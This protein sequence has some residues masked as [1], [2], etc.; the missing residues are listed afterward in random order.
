MNHMNEGNSSV[1]QKKNLNCVIEN[2]F[3]L[4]A[5]ISMDDTFNKEK[6]DIIKYYSLVKI[7]FD[8]ALDVLPLDTVFRTT[9][10][11]YFH[12]QWPVNFK[13]FVDGIAAKPVNQTFMSRIVRK[14]SSSNDQYIK[15]AFFG[16]IIND[17]STETRKI[18]RNVMNPLWPKNFATLSGVNES[19]VIHAIRLRC[20]H[21]DLYEKS[22]SSNKT[23]CTKYKKDNKQ[24]ISDEEK[25]VDLTRRLASNASK[26]MP[27][28]WFPDYWL[29]FLYCSIPA[30]SNMRTSF[31][32]DTTQVIDQRWVPVV[33]NNPKALLQQ[34]ASR[35]QKRAQ[36]ARLHNRNIASAESSDSEASGAK[37]RNNYFQHTLH[38]AAPAPNKVFKH[39]IL[40]LRAQLSLYDSDSQ[41]YAELQNRLR[42]V[43]EEE[44]Q[45]LN[46]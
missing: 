17:Y 44:D 15:D 37:D 35:N 23:Y 18:I 9:V 3:T 31:K 10:L 30:G 6:T 29:T 39:K 14:D 34:C 21:R 12:N 22:L 40:N 46:A 16:S 25:N 43:L 11:S 20:F 19:Q 7:A 41:K 8:N 36:E 4:V 45:F 32:T 27:T 38:F 33:G 24:E 13:L 1:E 28:Y 2:M 26:V 5:C 42:K